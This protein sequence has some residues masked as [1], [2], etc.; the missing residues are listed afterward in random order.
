MKVL[1]GK[2][3]RVSALYIIEEQLYLTYMFAINV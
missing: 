2:L 1:A 3:L